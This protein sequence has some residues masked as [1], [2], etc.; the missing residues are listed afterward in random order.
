LTSRDQGSATLDLLT[1]GRAALA[2]GAWE[3]ARDC[4]EQALRRSRL[5]QALEGLGMAASRLSDAEAAVDARKRAYWLYR[6]RDDRRAAGRV[7]LWLALDF[8][9]LRGQPALASDW[10]D[11]ARQLL[12]ELERI[13]EHGWLALAEGELALAT[14]ERPA[15]VQ[16]HAATAARI[17]QELDVAELEQAAAALAERASAQQTAT[18]GQLHAAPAPAALAARVAPQ[19]VD[20][21]AAPPEEA[22]AP[23]DAAIPP[24]EAMP[25]ATEDAAPL[26]AEAPVPAAETADP[27]AEI[28]LPADEPAAPDVEAARPV[29][30]EA[31]APADEEAPPLAEDAGAVAAELPP[32]TPPEPPPEQSRRDRPAF[33][34]AGMGSRAALVGLAAVLVL[35]L[36]LALTRSPNPPSQS[37]A[38]PTG[39][40][41]AAAIAAPTASGA[42]PEPPTA[43]PPA[44]AA[45]AAPATP[46]AAKASAVA[47]SN[48]GSPTAARPTTA[49][50]TTTPA[51][52]PATVAPA[53]LAR[54]AVAPSPTAAPAPSPTTPPAT[55]TPSAAALYR[56]VVAAEAAVVSGELTASFESNGQLQSSAQVRFDFGDGGRPPRLRIATTYRGAAGSQQVE[57][58]AIGDRWWQ[59]RPDGGWEA[60]PPREGVW[61]QAQTY[62]PQIDAVPPEQIALGDAP[63]TLRWR[64][65]GRDADIT[66]TIDPATG[67][68]RQLRQASR[69]GK[70][71]LTV[72]YAGWNGPVD[73]Q[74]PE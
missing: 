23:A 57:Q 33:F 24:A 69:D 1:N 72:T 32:A 40:A 45:T 50:P 21:P 51:A 60:I 70:T 31:P 30:E 34:L 59:R 28:A 3:E 11:H 19:P 58:I 8:Y 18:N 54:T 46:A 64:D 13:P 35:A 48:A 43:R 66:L 9:H 39:A 38:G 5:P 7:A 65:Q 74:P 52:A 61:G 17:G 67:A 49:R 47:A 6:V 20:E 27:A 10:L 36:G 44:P 42:G 41:N 62:L 53:T 25:A 12:E 37:A 15:L 16:Q 14:G 4:F 26:A 22:P 68:P 55:A 29:E 63:A 2:H 71:I 56:Q 73:I